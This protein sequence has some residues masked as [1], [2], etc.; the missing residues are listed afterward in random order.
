MKNHVSNLSFSLITLPFSY[1]DP[2][3]KV[4]C[5]E[6]AICKV[7]LSTGKAFCSCP[8]DMLGDPYVGCGKRIVF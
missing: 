3:E 7:V 4:K 6:F 5:G 1:T 8:F 2:C